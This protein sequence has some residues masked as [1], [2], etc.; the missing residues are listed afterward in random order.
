MTAAFS[1]IVPFHGDLTNLSQCVTALDL[2][3][4]E[5]ELII[6]ADGPVDDC[7]PLAAGHGARVIHVPR[8]SGPAVARNLGA[9]AATG[10]VLVFVDSDV[11]VSRSGLAR[12]ISIFHDRP[13][14]TA[15][16]GA[17]DEAPAHRGF[18]SQ[19]KNL[20]HAFVHRTAA[21]KAQTFWAGLGAV[22]RDAFC[23]VGGFDE[24]FDRPSVEDIDPS[25]TSGIAAFR[26]RN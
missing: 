23:A 10:D 20:S 24:R 13:H 4:P 16:F 5:S 22:R 7:E 6:V 2:R 21:P 3:P 11:V 15:A 25:L 26:G 18:M 19:Y 14:P 8:P 12:L 9:A 17:Y 1:F